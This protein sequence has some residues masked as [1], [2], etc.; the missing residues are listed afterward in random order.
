M[1]PNPESHQTTVSGKDYLILLERKFPTK[2]EIHR[3]CIEQTKNLILTTD[4]KE[5]A[6]RLVNGYNHY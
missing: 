3:R 2:Y 4:D 6:E 5:F 1:K